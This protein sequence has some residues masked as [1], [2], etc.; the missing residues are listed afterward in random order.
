MYEPGFLKEMNEKAQDEETGVVH[1]ENGG[2]D[3]FL[4]KDWMVKKYGLFDG[5][6]R[7]TAKISTTG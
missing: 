3:I 1:G 5:L 4:L 7:G 6:I 2:W